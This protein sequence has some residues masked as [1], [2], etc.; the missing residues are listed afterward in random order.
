ML[1][2]IFGIIIE[3]FSELRNNEQ[4]IDKDK[5]EICFI[6]G[7]DKESCEKKGEKL[8]E[9]LEK[10]HNIWTYV[11]YILGLRFVDI[12][13]TNAINSYVIENLERKELMWFPYD[14]TKTGEEDSKDQDRD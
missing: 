5:R 7:I 8:Q 2:M 12:Q 3:A 11:E 13:E 9:H 4:A 10:V 1:N 14:E 6:C